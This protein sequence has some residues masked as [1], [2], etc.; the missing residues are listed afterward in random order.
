VGFRDDRVS[1]PL[2][3]LVMASGEQCLCSFP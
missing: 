3:G 1:E 2:Q